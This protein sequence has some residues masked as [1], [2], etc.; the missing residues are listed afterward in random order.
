LLINAYLAAAVE[1]VEPL[2]VLAE[3]EMAG[4]VA[5]AV[6]VEEIPLL[7]F[8]M[9]AMAVLAEAAVELTLWAGLMQAL[10]AQAA[11]AQLVV[12]AEF[13]ILLAFLISLL[14]GWQAA[15]QVVV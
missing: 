2:T 15:E 10:R 6:D 14:L 4:M 9:A 12:L 11:L 8:I 13:P 7:L 3:E 1:E 5:A